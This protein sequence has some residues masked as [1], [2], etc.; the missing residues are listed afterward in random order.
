MTIRWVV[1]TNLLLHI[2]LV[3][4]ELSSHRSPV[5][6]RTNML[7]LRPVNS[8]LSNQLNKHPYDRKSFKKLKLSQNNK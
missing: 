4:V 7:L 8:S 2:H 1:E 3:T 6:T 5:L